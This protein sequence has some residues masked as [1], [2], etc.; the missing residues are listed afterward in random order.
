MGSQEWKVWK[1]NRSWEETDMAGVKKDN[2]A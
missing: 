2:M 1:Q